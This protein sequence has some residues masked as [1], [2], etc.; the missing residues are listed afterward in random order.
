MIKPFVQLNGN[1]FLP[2]PLGMM[3]YYKQ[4]S[5]SCRLILK[6][7]SNTYSEYRWFKEI[8]SISFA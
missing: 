4:L 3:V 8:V 6:T 7:N 1:S 5:N 2:F